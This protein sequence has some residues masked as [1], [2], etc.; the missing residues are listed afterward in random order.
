MSR[1]IFES[2]SGF[3]L[4][5]ILV[6][7]AVLSVCLTVIAHAFLS[8]FRA[9]KDV[10]SYSIALQLM[11]NQMVSLVQKGFIAQSLREN[12]AYAEPFEK[13]KVI[14]KTQPSLLTDGDIK[15]NEVQLSVRWL[16]ENIPKEIFMTT[17]LFDKNE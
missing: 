1:G 10:E 11:E 12:R 15:I 14:L 6:A 17:L 2:I 7:A 9:L 3:S 4:L 13:Y 8:C 5:E 16:S